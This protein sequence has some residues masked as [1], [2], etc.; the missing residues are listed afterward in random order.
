[1]NHGDE[2]RRWH[3]DK[4]VPLSAMIVIVLQTIAFVW[5]L[6]GLD[7]TALQ[8]TKDIADMKIEV[9]TLNN[10]IANI[11]SLPQIN[12]SE[13]KNLKSEMQIL[14]ARVDR[15]IDEQNRRTEFLRKQGYNS[16]RQT[17]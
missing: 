7:K 8:S 14:S 13:I 5:W 15:V 4:G 17:R 9:R 3:M 12:A 2:K 10:S 6:A 16:T 1:M 11:S